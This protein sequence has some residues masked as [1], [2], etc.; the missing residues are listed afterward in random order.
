MLNQVLFKKPLVIGTGGGNDIVSAC[1]IVS[2]LKEKGI[3]ADLAGLCSPGAWHCYECSLNGEASVNRVTEHARRFIPS[4]QP[5]NLSFIDSLLP[6]LLRQEEIPAEVYNLSCRYGTSKL[7]AGLKD[8]VE[9]NGYD[10]IIAV[11]VGGDILARG[12]KDPTILSPLMDFT[13]LYCVS[14]LRVPSVLVE[15][16]LQTDGELRPPGCNEI[17]EE[18][19][20]NKI[21]LEE[22]EIKSTDKPVQVFRNLSQGVNSIR[23][24]HAAAMALKTLESTSD[25]H[26]N[27]RA[28]IRV[29]DKS[30]VYNFPI[31]LESKYFGKVF[32]MDL[33]RLAETRKLAF[34]YRNTLELFLKTKRI[35][36]T[37]TEM[38][39]LYNRDSGACLWLALA[40]PQLQGKQ[41]TELLNYGLDN[42]ARHADVALLWKEDYENNGLNLL[43]TSV[44]V[45]DFMI[46][47]MDSNKVS[48]VEKEI[49]G[50]LN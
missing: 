3:N 9:K 15:F 41:R 38:D 23:R 47:G 42:L 44:R 50:V 48:A 4:N 49:K 26:E 13:T 43:K 20:Q 45:N 18:L 5:V 21:V 25:L 12:K 37:K 24:G 22:A 27:Y 19:K 40:C 17:L 1:L 29:L 32:V 6:N 28:K 31:V 34:P 46:T 2:D 33:K 10:G 35:V 36:N 16:G 14:Q 7:I 30:V 39:L 11:D 8:L